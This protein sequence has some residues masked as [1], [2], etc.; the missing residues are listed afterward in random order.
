[1]ETAQSS[2]SGV[3]VEW[4]EE[5]ASHTT[6]N[7][8]IVSQGLLPNLL[9]QAV[10]EVASKYGDRHLAPSVVFFIIV[11]LVRNYDPSFSETLIKMEFGKYAPDYSEQLDLVTRGRFSMS[12]IW[13]T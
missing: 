13:K 6:M 1:M 7:S 12:H 11:D 8:E 9:R 5:Y 3:S 4:C 2:S 10:D